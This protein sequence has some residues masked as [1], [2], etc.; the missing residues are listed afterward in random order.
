[1]K[2]IFVTGAPGSLWST[3]HYNVYYSLSIDRSDYQEERTCFGI[4][5]EDGKIRQLNH[6][7]SYFDPGM[8][9]GD[10]FGQLD[11]YSKEECEAEFDRPFSG[12]GIRIIR[13]HVFAHH[14]DFIKATWP[15]CPLVLAYRTDEE[16]EHW[17]FHTGGF[18]IPY[19][20]YKGYYKDR[21]TMVT[22]IAEQNIDILKA[23]NKYEGRLPTSNR[24]FADMIGIER[25]PE[26]F[27]RV[28]N[29]KTHHTISVKVL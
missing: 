8:E 9:F 17:W 15:E 16:C 21:P 26:E 7:G 2:Y 6:A 28:F 14:I 1:M 25:P 12:T 4:P 22:K 20:S 10:W 5:Q 3:I 27:Y 11:Q 23:W 13:S 18:D 29:D 19:P 24:N